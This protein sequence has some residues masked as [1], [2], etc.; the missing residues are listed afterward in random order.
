MGTLNR[1]EANMRTRHALS[2]AAAVLLV[3]PT[4]SLAQAP[5][6]EPPPPPPTDAETK[7][8]GSQI[9]SEEAE[10]PPPEAERTWTLNAGGIHNGGNT[11]SLG[12]YA[13]SD[14]AW[15][16]RPHEFAANYLFNIGFADADA[17]GPGD[18]EKTALNS[19]LKLRYNY[20]LSEKDAIYAGFLHRY[21]YFARLKSRFRLDA[22]YMRVLWETERQQLRGEIGLAAI[23]DVRFGQNLEGTQLIRPKGQ[24]N[25]SARLY[26]GYTNQINE[27]VFFGTG[28]EVLDNLNKLSEKSCVDLVAA[29]CVNAD[30]DP[31]R[32]LRVNWDAGLTAKL[33][34]KLAVGVKFL[35]AYDA[36]P[37]P[38]SEKIDTTTIFS[39]VYT[40]L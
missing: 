37:V 9:I 16:D 2:L 27:N 30:V 13:G 36:E 20:Y 40:L 4:L 11:R 25:L 34:D 5:E 35:L 10:P 31:F 38:G 12:L 33:W 18:F 15:K 39:L 23:Y 14:Y 29:N 17:G 28:V 7:D 22:G 24:F 26:L 1:E 8:A 3:A 6:V 32:D 19:N 21:D